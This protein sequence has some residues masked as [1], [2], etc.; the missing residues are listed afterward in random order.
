MVKLARLSIDDVVI[1]TC[2]GSGGF[3]ME[4]MEIMV[5]MAKDDEEKIENIK[6]E[7]LIGMEIDSVLFALACS[8][9][10][11]HGD[12]RSNL[13]YRSSLLDSDKN[14]KLINSSDEILFD[15]IKELKPTKS[16][17]NPPYENN[18]PIEFTLQAIDYIEPNGKLVIIMP[19][20]TLNMNK[21]DKT[22]ELLEKA[23]LDFVIKMPLNLFSEQKR[24]VNTS[25][26]GFTKTKHLYDDEVLFVNLKDDGFE[27]IQPAFPKHLTMI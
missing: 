16:I 3:L 21:D 10:F 1:D 4:A 9:M 27:S 15:Y 13:L 25:I 26:F 8:N 14:G 18:N 19:T 12:G 11:L 2:M 6:K 24:I 20:P 17:I 7:Q 23:K 22:K 5:N